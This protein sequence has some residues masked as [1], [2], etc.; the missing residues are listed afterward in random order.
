MRASLAQAPRGD[1]LVPPPLP[2]RR[3]PQEVRRHRTITRAAG[4]RKIVLARYARNRRLGDALQQWAF[5]ALRGSPGARA[6]YYQQLRGRSIGHQ[7][8]LRLLAN[9]VADRVR[10][11]PGKRPLVPQVGQ[12]LEGYLL[13]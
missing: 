1:R 10:P 8:A 4:T 3:G 13:L 2:R 11:F 6:Y 12:S 9:L 5:C 7:A